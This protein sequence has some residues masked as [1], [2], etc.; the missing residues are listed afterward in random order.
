MHNY[1]EG[2]AENSVENTVHSNAYGE[3]NSSPCSQTVNVGRK[4]A[5][6]AHLLPKNKILA[7]GSSARSNIRASA[8]RWD[9]S[10]VAQH[11][12]LLC[13]T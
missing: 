13:Y 3:S 6:T 11:A 4:L 5:V 8:V 1:F 10:Q 9:V 12:S 2:L 7:F